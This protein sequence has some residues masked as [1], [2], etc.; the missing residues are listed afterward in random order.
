MEQMIT[1]IPAQVKRKV[2]RQP[3][4]R[5][6]RSA[7]ARIEAAVKLAAIPF[8]GEPQPYKTDDNI[9]PGELGLNF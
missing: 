5:V 6:R 2:R 3:A 4:G 9:S 1:A 7:A 8:M